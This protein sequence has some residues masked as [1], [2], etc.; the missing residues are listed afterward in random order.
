[1]SFISHA[2]LR[3]HRNAAEDDASLSHALGIKSRIAAAIGLVLALTGIAISVL[4]ELNALSLVAILIIATGALCA[5]RSIV[6]DSQRR[7]FAAESPAPSTLSII[8]AVTCT[9]AIL[10]CIGTTAYGLLSSTPSFIFNRTWVL[11]NGEWT[12]NGRV[13]SFTKGLSAPGLTSNANAASTQ[14]A[15]SSTGVAFSGSDSADSSGSSIATQPSSTP[16]PSLSGLSLTSLPQ[17]VLFT[18]SNLTGETVQHNNALTDTDS[19]QSLAIESV[20][21]D[22]HAYGYYN[23]KMT[24]RNNTDETILY[25]DIAITALSRNGDVLKQDTAHCMGP[26]E[27]G[28][29]CE[30]TFQI[31][32]SNA[33]ALMPYTTMWFTSG[34]AS[35]AKDSAANDSEQHQDAAASRTAP[36]T[37]FHKASSGVPAIPL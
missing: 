23:G 20:T 32:S 26:I 21:I 13:V 36:G 7:R 15:A 8:T 16:S 1:M 14:N 11:E 9:V 12:R 27:T 17:A 3:H 28:Q 31:G 4:Q 30:A 10:A 24:L 33:S 18:G 25:A 37:L 29:T 34:D 5:V 35:A 6:L 19:A 22:N 2:S